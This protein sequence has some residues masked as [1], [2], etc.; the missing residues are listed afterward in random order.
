MAHLFLPTIGTTPPECPAKS[1]VA[2]ENEL[3]GAPA[4]EWDINGAGD[5]SIQGFA[6]EMS[7]AAGEST[8]FKVRTDALSYRMDVYRM[9]YYGG[10]GARLVETINAT[11]LPAKQP[12][13]LFEAAT[14]LV[15]CSNW[16]VSLSWRVPAAAVSGI[17]FGRLVRTDD[18]A[19]ATWRADNSPVVG[20]PKFAR[21]GWDQRIPPDGST[22]RT[23]AYGAENRRRTLPS[24]A[25]GTPDGTSHGRR[26]NALREPRASHVYFVVRDDERASEV[27]FQTMDSTWQ[28]Y[29]CWGTTN[30]YGFAC[31]DPSIH[32]GSPPPPD[33]SR[34]AY[35][36]SY[37]RPLATR[38]YRMSNAP[39]NSE[40]PMVRWL[41]RNGFDVS[42][43]SGV[44]ADKLGARLAQPHAGGRGEK[45]Q[46][47]RA[48]H[49]LYLSVGHDEYWSGAQRASVTAA[50]D[51]GMHL[52]FFS[53]NEVYWRSRWEPDAEGHAHRTLVVYKETQHVAKLDPMASEW[54]G[55]WRDGRPI[56]PLGPQPEN[57]LTGTIFTVNAWRNDPMAV[58]PK[59]APLRFWRNTSIAALPPAA[60]TPPA[61]LVQGLLGHECGLANR[62]T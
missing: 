42:Y 13:C 18:A 23:H 52:A 57:S 11:K 10:A 43:W 30:T 22:R 14:L 9:G 54:T 21:E 55:T 27:L 29:N 46:H 51:A 6:T 25:G 45:A 58:P 16:A 40:Y 15:D 2:L 17:Y 12:E 36:A 34:R 47:R 26:R 33:A 28:A 44:D 8:D 53:G 32:A 3:K 48:R 59:Y 49:L 62:T 20:D 35:K 39:F 37:N 4:A 60:G 56:N 31:S 50:R 38:A 1:P 61:L 5:P 41:E 7:V 19:G 24:K